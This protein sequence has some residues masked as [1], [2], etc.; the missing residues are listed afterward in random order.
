MADLAEV[1]ARQ[2]AAMTE[3]QL[4]NTVRRACKEAGWMH[5]HQ[6]NSQRTEPG[7]PD[8]FMV[9]GDRILVRELKTQVGRITEHQARWLDA[10]AGAGLDVGVWRPADAVSGLIWEVLRGAD[11]PNRMMRHIKGYFH[12]RR[13]LLS[14]DIEY[15]LT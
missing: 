5:V 1:R 14:G 12:Y 3:A 6:H 13:I 8:C 10:L 4:L 11:D 9:K 2:A 15:M 7:W